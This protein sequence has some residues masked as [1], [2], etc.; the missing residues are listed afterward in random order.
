MAAVDVSHNNY[1][2]CI[3]YLYSIILFIFKLHYTVF[4]YYILIF[5][6][7]IINL[8]QLHDNNEKGVKAKIVIYEMKSLIRYTTWFN[9]Y[10]FHQFLNLQCV[11]N[12]THPKRNTFENMIYHIS[13]V[14]ESLYV[15]EKSWWHW[16]SND[17]IF[18]SRFYSII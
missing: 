3:Q 6:H 12:L 15:S 1:H 2:L 13:D 16:F 5:S 8:I 14:C 9:Y 11:S 17:F 18:S 4:D 10:K 7:F